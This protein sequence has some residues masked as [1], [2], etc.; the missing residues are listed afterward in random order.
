ML[1]NTKFKTVTAHGH[2]CL[3]LTWANSGICSYNYLGDVGTGLLCLFSP[4][5]L[6]PIML[7]NMLIFVL[8]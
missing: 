6:W 2:K 4:I 3:N 7:N 1:Y 8:M 5:I